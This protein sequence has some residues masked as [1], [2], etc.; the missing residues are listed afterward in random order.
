MPKSRFGDE[1]IIGILNEHQ[2]GPNAA[3]RCRKHGISD[4]AVQEVTVSHLVTESTGAGSILVAAA[5][6]SS[7]ALSDGATGP[8][9]EV[10]I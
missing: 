8:A 3:D 10:T 2:A 7:L 9:R 5:R 6:P 1:P 4:P